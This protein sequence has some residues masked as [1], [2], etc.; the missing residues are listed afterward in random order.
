MESC[1]RDKGEICTKKEEG[2][3]IVERREIRGV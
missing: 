2:I 3:S 1:D